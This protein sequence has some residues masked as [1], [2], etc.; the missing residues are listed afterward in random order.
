MHKFVFLLALLPLMVQAADAQPKAEKAE[1]IDARTVAAYQKLGARYGGVVK[2]RSGFPQFNEGKE[3]ARK[4]LPG[5]RLSSLADGKL[6]RLPQVS[7]PFALD[8]NY[9]EVTD[10]G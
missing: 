2:R 4:G 6:P 3:A 9:T 7:I 8:L 5:F 10:A 1:G